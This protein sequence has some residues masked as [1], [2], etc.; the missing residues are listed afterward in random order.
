MTTTQKNA[1]A[2]PATG[3]MVYDTD[4]DRPSVKTSTSWVTLES[5]DATFTIEL[6]A[7]QTAD[8]YAPD[9]LRINTTTN[10][11]G[12]PTVT[13]KVNDVAYT[14]TDLINQGDKITVEVDIASVV[15]LNVTY[16]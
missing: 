16:E 9:D 3:L 6:I 7:Q 5:K 14:L 12:S 2:S 13:L 8:F 15:N 1:I 4:L 11:V 10:I